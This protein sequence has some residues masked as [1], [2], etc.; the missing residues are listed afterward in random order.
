MLFSQEAFFCPHQSLTLAKIIAIM[1][2]THLNN[3]ELF[4]GLLMRI[5]KKAPLA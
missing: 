3:E 1:L 5:T 4:N 2:H